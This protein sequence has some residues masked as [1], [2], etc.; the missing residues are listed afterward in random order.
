MTEEQKPETK[1]S[2]S[3]ESARRSS[4]SNKEAT[5][6]ETVTKKRPKSQSSETATKRRPKPKIAAGKAVV[7]AM[8]QLQLL[9][10]RTPESVVGVTA[11]NEG[12]RVTIEVVES[13]RIPSTA[14][15]MAEYEVDIDA[16]GDLEG[17]S[18]TSRYFRG[19]T[20][21]E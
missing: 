15:I 2:S 9:T 4:A 14:D 10:T 12:W 5:N 7:A 19:R 8:K 17:Y 13:A 20:Q 16:D 18:R 11:H 21:G 6:R 3:S 1:T